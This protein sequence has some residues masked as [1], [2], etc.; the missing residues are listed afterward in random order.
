MIHFCC[1]LCFVIFHGN[2]DTSI[3]DY[4]DIKMINS[5]HGFKKTIRFLQK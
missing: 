5:K 2:C 3:E 4:I 1:L